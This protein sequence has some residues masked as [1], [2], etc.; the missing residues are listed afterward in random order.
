MPAA[1]HARPCYSPQRWTCPGR[2][3]RSHDSQTGADHDEGAV[4]ATEEL[5]RAA[6]AY[7]VRTI[8]QLL[9]FQCSASVLA[10]PV[11]FRLMLRP[12]AQHAFGDRQNTERSTGSF[13]PA[14]FGLLTC[15]HL[16][17]CQR[18]ISVWGLACPW[19]PTAKQ[20]VDV[21][22]HPA[23]TPQFRPEGAMSA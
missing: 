18:S 21:A 17:R 3:C 20:L 9:P 7:G 13:A 8:D 1:R 10:G 12:T 6:A 4:P 5:D 2:A 15:T 19:T 16:E 14:G 23:A 11:K 22:T